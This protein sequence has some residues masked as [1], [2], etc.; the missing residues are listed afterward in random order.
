[1]SI[2]R[3][4]LPLEAWASQYALLM[5]YVRIVTLA[6]ACSMS[7]ACAL[8]VVVLGASNSS[9]KGERSRHLFIG[10]TPNRRKGHDSTSLMEKSIEEEE[11]PHKHDAPLPYRYGRFNPKLLAITALT[12]RLG[13]SRGMIQLTSGRGTTAYP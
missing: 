9:N 3:L 5:P 1:M 6:V 12:R 13:S 10:N 8:S 11:H 4:S 7:L 2:G